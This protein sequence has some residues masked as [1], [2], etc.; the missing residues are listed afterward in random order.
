M[1][2]DLIE[3]IISSEESL[4]NRSI[5]SLLQNK[6]KDEL[7]KLAG[8]TEQF[9]KS[10]GNL[11]YRVRASLFLFVIYRFYLQKDKEITQQGQIPF[12]GIKAAFERDFENSIGILKIPL[13]FI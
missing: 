5:D 10:S 9:R 7:L 1:S 6:N 13:I 8:E 2:N 12:E 11:Y 3:T 4:R